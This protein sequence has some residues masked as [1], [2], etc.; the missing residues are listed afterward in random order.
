MASGPA[1]HS[2]SVWVGAPGSS[3]NAIPNWSGGVPS[4]SVAGVIDVAHAG[5]YQINV[6]NAVILGDLTLGDLTA[7]DAGGFELT[8]STITFNKVGGNA[9]Q[10]KERPWISSAIR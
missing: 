5:A 3:F 7:E 8:G 1:V 6:A 4:A 10:N 9:S 2:Q